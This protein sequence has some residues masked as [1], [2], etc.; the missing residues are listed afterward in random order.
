MEQHCF[1]WVDSRVV[2]R[3][4]N[5]FEEHVDTACTSTQEPAVKNA[6]TIEM[7]GA[8]LRHLLDKSADQQLPDPIAEALRKLRELDTGKRRRI[9]RRPRPRQEVQGRGN[10]PHRSQC[11]LDF[12]EL[13][14]LGDETG[15]YLS[16]RKRRDIALDLDGQ[17]LLDRIHSKQRAFLRGKPGPA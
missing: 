13:T 9:F 5:T 14:Q 6:A 2:Q 4:R 7:V 12:S 10:A 1:G 8:G 15:I 3:R 16:S 11:T 17:S